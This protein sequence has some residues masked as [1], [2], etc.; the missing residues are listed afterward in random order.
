[1]KEHSLSFETIPYL[2]QL[3]KRDL[4]HILSVEELKEKL[5]RKGEPIIEATAIN[6]GGVFETLKEVAKLVLGELRKTA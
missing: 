2:L 5:Q 6:G 1:L 3:N 4:P